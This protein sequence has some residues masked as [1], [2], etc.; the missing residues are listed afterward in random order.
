LQFDP[1]AFMIS[2]MRPYISEV[3]CVKCLDCVEICPYE[4]FHE[5]EDAVIVASP[6]DCIECT[7]CVD[8]CPYQAISM[9]D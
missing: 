2:E 5:R 1:K 4:V 8:S 7:A 3:L 6:E 9:D